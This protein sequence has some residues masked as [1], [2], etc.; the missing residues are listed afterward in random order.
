MDSVQVRRAGERFHTK[1]AWL[2]S[3]HSFAF[4]PHYREDRVQFGPLRVLNDDTVAPG[5]GFGTHPHREME[6]V[7]IVLE[8]ALAHKDTTGTEE[9][10]HAGEV[11]RMSAGT[12]V[13]HS[14]YNAS[15]SEPVKFLQI[16]LTPAQ[17]RLR[18]SY[19]QRDFSKEDRRNALVPVASGRGH[20]GA[21]KLHQDAAMFRLALEGD[22]KVSHGMGKGRRAFVFAIEGSLTVGGAP[23]GRRDA[24]AVEG[25]ESL[26]LAAGGPAEVLL[27]DLP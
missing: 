19:E 27:I 6:I 7:S 3:W 23:L 14:E 8:G 25:V 1:L 10:L 20:A 13:Q 12:G 4:G 5:G 17:P 2:D 21:L 15:E 22:G 11:Q 18:P 9:V 26:D 24:A 16:W